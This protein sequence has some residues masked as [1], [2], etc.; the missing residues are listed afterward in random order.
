MIAAGAGTEGV[1]GDGDGGDAAGWRQRRQ[2]RPMARARLLPLGT[3]AG[4]IKLSPFWLTVLIGI[5]N[6]P[7][8]E[9]VL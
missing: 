3:T 7:Q 8:K 1:V 2:K 6:L 9:I 5:H 4:N